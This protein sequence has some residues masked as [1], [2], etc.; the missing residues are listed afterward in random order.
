MAFDP[1]LLTTSL[2][3]AGVAVAIYIV[4]SIKKYPTGNEKMVAVWKAIRE[5]ANAYLR[6][7]K[8]GNVSGSRK[9]T[10]EAVS[11]R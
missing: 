5:G 1:L 10:S 6:R 8:P 7:R 11:R 4:Y 2:A 9:R 3:I